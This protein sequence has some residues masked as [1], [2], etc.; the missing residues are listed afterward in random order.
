MANWWETL[1]GILNTFLE[2]YEALYQTQTSHT[3]QEL[4][5]YLTDLN[6]PSLNPED[7][8]ALESSITQEEISQAISSFRP[9]KSPGLDG[10]PAE[11]YQQ[12]KEKL[13]PC[14]QKVF[15]AAEK[16]GYTPG[17]YERSLDC[18]NP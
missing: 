10:F 15:I 1:I 11:W 16:R 2:F 12:H 14:L 9:G 13:A 8:A 6:L 5:S 17:I 4:T 3:E 7:S 18:A